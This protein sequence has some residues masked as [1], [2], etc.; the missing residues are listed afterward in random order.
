MVDRPV[1][2]GE[3]DQTL[4]SRR[5]LPQPE[6]WAETPTVSTRLARKDPKWDKAQIPPYFIIGGIN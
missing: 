1:D 6:A 5:C 3:A 4:R 2:P